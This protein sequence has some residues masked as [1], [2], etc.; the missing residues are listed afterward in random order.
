[1]AGRALSDLDVDV[2]HDNSLAGP[3]LAFGSR[4]PTLVTTHGP[5]QGELGRYY[6]SLPEA[7]SLVAI[8]N[9]QRRLAPHLNWCATVYNGIPVRDYPFSAEK[10][11]FA[12]FLGRMSPEKAPHLAIDACREAGIDLVIAAKCNEPAERAY[13]EAEVKP[14]LGPGVEYVGE[15]GGQSK[16]DLFSRARCFVFPIQ[17]EEPFGIVMVE[18]MACGTPVVALNR[19]SVPEIVDDG[20]T[21][22][23]CTSPHE[24]PEA[25]KRSDV[26]AP[27]DCRRRALKFDVS[28][29]V[30]G[31]ELVF[32]RIA[33][34]SGSVR[35]LAV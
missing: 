31:Y 15:V 2:V 20:I 19:G 1:M 16:M 25:I 8:S 21:G 28:N 11:D 13:F 23:V 18:A 7:V 5:V 6:G 17:W 12:L 35:P 26:I 34:E 22:F 27:E 30:A 4:V 33:R 3:L 29:M 24:L 32:Q 14:R 9:A 10:D